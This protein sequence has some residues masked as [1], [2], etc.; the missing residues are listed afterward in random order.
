VGGRGFESANQFGQRTVHVEAA[1]KLEQDRCQ[2]GHELHQTRRRS[3]FQFGGN[4][5]TTRESLV[6]DAFG[7]LEQDRIRTVSDDF[8]RQAELATRAANANATTLIGF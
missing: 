6:A 2:C 4:S 1:L 8:H 7:K 5:T 3:L